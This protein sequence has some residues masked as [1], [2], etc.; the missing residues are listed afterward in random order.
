MKDQKEVENQN[1][2]FDKCVICGESS[3]YPA[4]YEIEHRNCYVEGVG[5]F[6]IECFDKKI[7]NKPF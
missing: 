2:N 3:P 1:E 7:K 6:C 5:Q 4:H